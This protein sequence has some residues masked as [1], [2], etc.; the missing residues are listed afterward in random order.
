[1]SYTV[2][3][4]KFRSQTFDEV[5]GQTPI[6]T[7]LRNAIS[8]G[9]VHHGYLFCGTRGVGKTS[10]ARILA[11]SL[12]C[13]SSDGPTVT[14]CGTC[15]SC[16]AVA[17]G[18]DMDVVEIDAASNTGVDNIRE[19]RNNAIYR[20]ARSRFKIYIIDEVH[21]LSTGAFNA[22][23]K[24]LEEPPDH[25]KFI[26]ATTESQKVPAT[27][28]SRVQQFDF[29]SIPAGDIAQ[30]LT[31]ICAEEKFEADEAALKRLARLANGSMRDGLSLLDQVMSMA[32]AKITAE[33]VNE[34]FPAAHDEL[35]ASLIDCLA[36][37]DAAGA[38]ET[39]DV[40]LG[41][42]YALDYWC[43]LLIG[44]IRDLMV[45]RVCGGETDLVDVPAGLRER[46]IEQAGRFDEGA[47]VYMITVLE[48]LR[49]SVKSSGSGRALVEAAIVRLAEAS[50]FS[51][52]ESLLAH[53]E[54]GGGG[55]ARPTSATPPHRTQTPRALAPAPQPS[56]KPPRPGQMRS[57]AESAAPAASSTVA[58]STE[59]EPSSSTAGA[60][61]PGR[62]RAVQA[63]P[64]VTSLPRAAQRVTQADL[65]AA[66]EEPLVQ[67]A[68]DV[69]GGNIVH[70]QRGAR[71]EAAQPADNEVQA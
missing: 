69:F 12:N 8:Q 42:G 52:I 26:F 25:V 55:G 58:A 64:Q 21:M 1:M 39:S 7:T 16:V 54:Q 59:P 50:K 44:Q 47:F 27:I 35:F 13:L 18:E 43:T 68:L 17:R 66:N 30:Q 31:R 61:R 23:L 63:R 46:L 56:S 11:K 3:A 57:R 33:M 41:Q 37:G 60:T 24:T 71:A 67:A 28:L 34:L 48:E 36:A 9:R 62:T 20:P 2:L 15:D 49:R 51:S 6:S 14:P 29:K 22:L 19:L 5:I 53:V 65:K 10:M 38:L 40:S 32:G 4:R 45:L 70:V